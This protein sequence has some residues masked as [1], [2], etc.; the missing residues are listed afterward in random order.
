MISVSGSVSGSQ[1]SSSLVSGS[2]EAAEAF[3]G[4]V[5]FLF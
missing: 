5:H 3:L 1:V 4:E 2:V